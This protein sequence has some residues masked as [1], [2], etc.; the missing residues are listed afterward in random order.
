MDRLAV[1]RGLEAWDIAVSL[2][3]KHGIEAADIV[4]DYVEALR[5]RKAAAM[6]AQNPTAGTPVLK[7][8]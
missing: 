8:R 4:L 6:R 1:D 5:E 7:T 3:R 2:R